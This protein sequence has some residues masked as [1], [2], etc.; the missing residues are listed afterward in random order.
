MIQNRLT[1][2]VESDGIKN[3]LC[4]I[5]D[6]EPQVAYAVGGIIGK[7]TVFEICQPAP[8]QPPC[9][10]M[11]SRGKPTA[12][13]GSVED[14]NRR[15]TYKPPR[16]VPWKLS[17]EIERVDSDE[18]LWNEIK[19]CIMEHID[20]PNPDDY[21]ILT[22]W[23]LATWTPEKWISF[24]FIALYSPLDCGKSR[25][26]EILARL[27][28]R[29]WLTTSIS[30]ASLY[31]VCDDWHPVLILD[32][33]EPLLKNPE[34]IA[35][36]NASYRRGNTVPRQTPMP[37]GTFRTDFY[38]TY[39]FRVLSGTHEPPQT[40][41]SRAILFHMRKSVRHLRLFINET[42]CDTLRN[43]LMTYRFKKI[44]GD[45]GDNLGVGVEEMEQFGIELGSGRLAEIFYCLYSV[46]PTPQLK[47]KI[48]E[49]AKNLN[50]EREA[51]LAAGDE[52]LCL[53]AILRCYNTG[54][55][56]HGLITIKSITDQINRDLEYNEAW[57][58]RKVGS[59]SSRLGFK[60]EMNRQKLTCIKWDEKLVA[61]L[62]S[63]S[64]YAVCF[65]EEQAPPTLQ[66]APSSPSHPNGKFQELP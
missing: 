58:H 15:V 66:N 36:L 33:V 45:E 40:L 3:I 24:P 18:Q 65:Q 57:T 5:K 17:G 28:L 31:R 22:A 64:R 13:V 37:D 11:E 6:D 20:M 21:E 49:Y 51:E 43:K 34:I 29:G 39:G 19:T 23:I 50:K 47:Q 14:K 38:E 30:V 12:Y 42:Q 63:D 4:S 44:L 54:D 55:M 7:H 56:T 62:K 1:A 25:V 8:H 16:V 2:T 27:S 52:S 10:A 9:Y 41:K 59:L 60:K 48:M 26:G 61:A 35:L 46:A 32:E 53:T